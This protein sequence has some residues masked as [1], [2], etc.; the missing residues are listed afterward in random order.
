MAVNIEIHP[1]TLIEGEFDQS[2]LRK[3]FVIPKAG[4]KVILGKGV[5]ISGIKIEIL[6]TNSTLVIGDN[7]RLRGQ[8]LIK[9]KGTNIYIGSETTF[10]DTYL[11]ASD[12]CGITIGRWCMF[13]RKIEVRVTDAHSV[14][15]VSAGKRVNLPGPIVIGD[16]VWVG[17]G[18]IIGKGVTIGS[19]NIIGANSFVNKSV[20]ESQCIIAG[21][22]AAVVKRGVTWHR[23]QKDSFS[24]EELGYWSE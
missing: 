2:K 14:V 12:G 5:D 3:A 22:P 4:N 7:C 18:A 6:G 24:K 21:S 1:D 10:V 17:V 15:D 19:D 11:L 13:S 20:L 8:I 9:G 23:S 16:H